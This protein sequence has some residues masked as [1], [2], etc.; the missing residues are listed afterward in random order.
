[1]NPFLDMMHRDPLRLQSHYCHCCSPGRGSS[2]R[3]EGYK[4]PNTALQL[5][6]SDTSGQRVERSPQAAWGR[7]RH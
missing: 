1:M 5:C 3:K 4:D 2:L 7:W 6:T